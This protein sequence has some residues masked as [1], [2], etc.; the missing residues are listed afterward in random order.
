MGGALSAWGGQASV[1]LNKTIV[2]H[3]NAEEEG[4]GM[5]FDAVCTVYLSDIRNNT[6]NNGGYILL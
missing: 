5:C 3:N 2:A 1:V 4:G 6:A